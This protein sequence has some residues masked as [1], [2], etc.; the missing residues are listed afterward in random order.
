MG[1]ARIC[2][3]CGK[4]YEYCPNCRSFESRPKW[5]ANWDCEECKDIWKILVRY[6]T[7]HI[8]KEEVKAVLDSYGI[9]DVSKYVSP[10]CTQLKTI[11]NDCKGKKKF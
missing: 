3:T 9:E 1:Y 5:M 11:L 2:H 4:E 10:I 6:N 7:E 8:S